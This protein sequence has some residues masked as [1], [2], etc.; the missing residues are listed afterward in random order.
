MSLCAGV[1][2]RTGGG[3]PSPS[4]VGEDEVARGEEVRGDSGRA[5]A[6]ARSTDGLRV[7]RALRCGLPFK[8]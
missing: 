2:E 3:C 5:M 8:R 7:S 4:Q 6:L 1:R